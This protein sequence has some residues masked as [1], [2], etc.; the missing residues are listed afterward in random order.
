M[1]SRG[2]DLVFNDKCEILLTEIR[3]SRLHYLYS[4]LYVANSYFSCNLA[5]MMYFVRVFLL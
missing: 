2:K 1:F 4:M 3:E 5:L